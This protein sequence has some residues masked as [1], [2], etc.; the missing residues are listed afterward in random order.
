[1]PKAID[2]IVAFEW[3]INICYKKFHNHDHDIRNGKGI[4]S[5]NVNTIKWF[6]AHIIVRNKKNMLWFRKMTNFAVKVCTTYMFR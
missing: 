5:I 1:M 4:P 2:L 3:F 6:I